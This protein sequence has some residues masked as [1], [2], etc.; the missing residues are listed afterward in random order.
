M[1]VKTPVLRGAAVATAMRRLRSPI[2]GK[3][4]WE[5]KSKPEPDRC[6][7]W[8]IVIA[9]LGV[10]SL[11]ALAAL[12][13]AIAGVAVRKQYKHGSSSTSVISEVVAHRRVLMTGFG[14]FLNFTTNPSEQVAHNLNRTCSN[15]PAT[16]VHGPVRVCIDALILDVN[17]TGAH[18]VFNMLENTYDSF[19]TQLEAGECRPPCMQSTM[20]ACI[21]PEFWCDCLIPSMRWAFCIRTA[22]LCNLNASHCFIACILSDCLPASTSRHHIAC[23]GTN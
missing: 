11:L 22:M 16:H 1:A 7:V 3:L 21:S 12:G 19:S 8:S 13:G 14:P 5:M 9:L 10:G 15:L 18:T 23:A 20:A 2:A 6:S 4:G 17:Q